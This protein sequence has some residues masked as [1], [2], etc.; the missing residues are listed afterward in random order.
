MLACI[1]VC[2]QTKKGTCIRT[3]INTYIRRMCPA[4]ELVVCCL[5]NSSCTRKG[6]GIRHD[7]NRFD[8]PP[9]CPTHSRHGYQGWVDHQT[10]TRVLQAAR[11]NNLRMPLSWRPPSLAVFRCYASQLHSVAGRVEPGPHS[12]A[13][14]SIGSRRPKGASVIRQLLQSTASPLQLESA[15]T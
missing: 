10:G 11:W 15:C 4:S 9:Q 7:S 1:H 14:H 12:L 6:S 2:I 3:Y 5:S 13:E 8:L